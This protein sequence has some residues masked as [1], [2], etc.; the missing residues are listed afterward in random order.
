MKEIEYPCSKCTYI[1]TDAVD[2]IQHKKSQHQSNSS[3]E[4]ELEE[5]EEE[6]VKGEEEEEGEYDEEADDLDDE[7]EEE[8]SEEHGDTIC[9]NLP[10]ETSKSKVSAL[11]PNEYVQVES[12]D[13][14]SQE[15]FKKLKLDVANEEI[16]ETSQTS[17]L[18]KDNRSFTCSECDFL[19]TTSSLLNLHV[20]MRHCGGIKQR[21]P[22]HASP[23]PVADTRQVSTERTRFPC[24][25]CGLTFTTYGNMNQHMMSKH[26]GVRYPCDMCSYSATR[27]TDLRRHKRAKHMF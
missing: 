6:E 2:I 4:E 7:S 17:N 23:P 11:V 5:E 21:K 25:D 15:P 26:L 9:N 16:I 14:S 22:T 10:Q 24:K 18:V 8:A 12:S 13:Y 1:A 19:T 3:D 20:R 27:T